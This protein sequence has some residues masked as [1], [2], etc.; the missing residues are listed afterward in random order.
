MKF[1]KRNKIFLRRF[2]IFFIIISSIFFY[3]FS[4]G[5]TERTKKG[6]SDGC[7]CHG[8]SPNS[9]VIVSIEGPSSLII[10]QKATY[11]LT[12][13]G[14]PLVRAGTN[15]AASS[16]TLG[17]ISG[18]GLQSAGGELTHTSPKA[19]V[20]GTVTFQFEYTA[21]STSGN[22]TLFANGNSV[23]FNGSSSGDQWNFA[24]DKAVVVST[25]SVN[26]NPFINEFR[27]EQNYPNP[28]NPGTTIKFS[29]PHSAF[30]TLKV[31]DLLGREVATLVNEPK[32][33]GEYEVEFHADKYGLS[34][35]VYLYKLNAGSFTSTKKFVYLQ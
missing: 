30:I 33:T 27:L 10:G 4:S 29:S 34:S 17:V 21:P 3:A 12:I 7:N 16:G 5:I 2:S 14:G 24:A 15:I 26:D 28:F 20:S 9:S 1:I 8:S 35:G 25:T 22:V 11:S 18:S 32:Q 19:P 6:T 31:Y 23:N 13:S